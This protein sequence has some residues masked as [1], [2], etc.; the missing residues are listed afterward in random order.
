ME[1]LIGT[2]IKLV[3]KDKTYSGNEPLYY[4]GQHTY[5][6]LTNNGFEAAGIVDDVAYVVP[7]ELWNDNYR[8]PK[9][10]NPFNGYPIWDFD[11]FKGGYNYPDFLPEKIVDVDAPYLHEYPWYNSMQESIKRIREFYLNKKI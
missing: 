9:G 2:P 10:V 1:I 7:W 8:K 11:R 6:W 3:Y 5:G 4:L